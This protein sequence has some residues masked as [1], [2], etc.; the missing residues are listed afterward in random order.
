MK[1]LVCCDNGHSQILTFKALSLF[2][3][4]QMSEICGL[5]DGTSKYY[6][7]KESLLIGKCGICWGQLKCSLVDDLKASTETADRDIKVDET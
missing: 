1:I 3:R 6:D 5:I 4:E 7:P 2:N